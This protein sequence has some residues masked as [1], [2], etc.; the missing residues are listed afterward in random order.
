M[1]VFLHR[2]F[3]ALVCRCAHLLAFAESAFHVYITY[4][5]KEAPSADVLGLFQTEPG[6]SKWLE[7]S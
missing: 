1:I 2:E 3:S 5:T 4:E 6:N 7:S